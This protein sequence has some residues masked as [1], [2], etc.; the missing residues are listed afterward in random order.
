MFIGELECD[1]P[2]LLLNHHGEDVLVFERLGAA[3]ATREFDQSF[4]GPESGLSRC[5]RGRC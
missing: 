3:S 2:R 4:V 5:A 1:F